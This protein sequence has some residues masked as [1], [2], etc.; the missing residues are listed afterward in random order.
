MHAGAANC[1]LGHEVHVCFS[2]AF[3]FPPALTAAS[4]ICCQ[5]PAGATGDVYPGHH[6]V[7]CI[8]WKCDVS[9]VICMTSLWRLAFLAF[10][11]LS[12]VHQCGFTMGF[13]L[14]LGGRIPRSCCPACRYCSHAAPGPFA[15]M[16][17]LGLPLSL[18]TFCDSYI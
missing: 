11:H 1:C 2:L 7:V 16:C 3:M 4:F 10:C 8:A 14:A 18:L 12:H 5:S 13:F 15:E 6:G 17:V 9:I